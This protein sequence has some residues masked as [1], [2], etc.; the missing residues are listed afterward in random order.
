LVYRC[1]TLE[2]WDQPTYERALKYISARGWRKHEPGDLGSPE[3]PGLL[4]AAMDLLVNTGVTIEDLAKEADL[5]VSYIS[6]PVGLL[7]AGRR[8]SVGF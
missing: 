6:E 7:E 4:Q 2:V 5:P 1:K 8:P 3:Q